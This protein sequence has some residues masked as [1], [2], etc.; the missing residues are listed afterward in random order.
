VKSE[1]WRVI[2]YYGTGPPPLKRMDVTV[3][4]DADMRERYLA[5]MHEAWALLLKA[6]FSVEVKE[7][8]LKRID[9]LRDRLAIVKA[10][11]DAYIP[12]KK[13]RH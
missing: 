5:E 11:Y 10:R 9:E 4:M 6:T 7:E 2:P 8:K 3:A 13:P 1:S 12:N